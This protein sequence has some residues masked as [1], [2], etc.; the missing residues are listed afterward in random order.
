[1]QA[2]GKMVI[3]GSFT[4]IGST[5]R[6]YVARLNLDGTLDATFNASVVNGPNG[7]ISQVARQSDGRFLVVGS[8]TSI[9]STPRKGI[10]RLNSDGSV[11]TTFDPGTGSDGSL[12]T[13]A[14]QADGK[15]L[16]GGL[17]HSFNG[18]S[19]RGYLVRLNS[20]GS[21]DPSFVLG[22]SLNGTVLGVTV[23]SD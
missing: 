14:V 22:S 20:D 1:S 8:F 9:G 21:I 3:A 6:Q 11:D 19:T 12:R 2:D 13:V 15:I 23:Q 18:D 5:S 16:A 7:S 4:A 17:F 10:A